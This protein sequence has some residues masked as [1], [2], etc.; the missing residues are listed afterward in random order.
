M[1]LLCRFLRAVV[2]GEELGRQHDRPEQDVPP[3]LADQ[4]VHGVL[5]PLAMAAGQGLRGRLQLIEDRWVRRNWSRKFLRKVITAGQTPQRSL[6]CRR[7]PGRAGRPGTRRETTKST[8]TRTANG[9][10]GW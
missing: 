9:T 8:M 7:R 3:E 4:P 2:A 10:P 1:A 5:D 6:G